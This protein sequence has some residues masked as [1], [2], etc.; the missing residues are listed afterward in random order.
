MD[1][2]FSSVQQTFSPT[3]KQ[4]SEAFGTA[5]LTRVTNSIILYRGGL[6]A[7]GLSG[8]IRFGVNI[9]SQK[10]IDILVIIFRYLYL[11]QE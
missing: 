8:R 9:E 6:G 2:T 1:C 10:R 7:K 11:W 5:K 3:M 4:L